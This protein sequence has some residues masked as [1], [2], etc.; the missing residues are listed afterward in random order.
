MKNQDKNK[1]L[2]KGPDTGPKKVHTITGAF[3]YTGRFIAEI[4]HKK[5]IPINTLTNTQNQ[6]AP[7]YGKLP[8]YPLCFSDKTR[9]VSYL[10]ETKVLYNNYWVRFNHRK[11]THEEAVQ[12][13][14]VLIDAAK[15]AG[16]ERFI[17][18]SITNPSEDSPHE[19]FSGKARIEKHLMESGMSYCILRPAV[20]FGYDDILI[21]NIAWVLRHLPVFGVFGKGDYSLQPIYV[22][23]LANLAV[24]YS[25]KKDNSIYNALGPETFTFR[26]LVEKMALTFGIKAR[27]FSC[28]PQAA[29]WIGKFVGLLVRDI[30]ITREEIG[31]IMDNLLYAAPQEPCLYGKTFLTEYLKENKNTVGRKYSSELKR[32]IR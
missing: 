5:G 13:S 25:Q 14:F 11:F 1:S 23:D 2:N 3:G 26:Q 28:P 29:Y 7:L 20:L 12:N 22:R 24:E 30:I 9:L 16:V 31:G 15:E 10:K 32:R 6:D 21:N 4:L 18:I 8:A 17:H 27:V 19:Y